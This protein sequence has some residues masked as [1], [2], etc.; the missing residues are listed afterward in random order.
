MVTNK[1]FDQ[2]LIGTMSTKMVVPKQWKNSC[3]LEKL[4]Q[5]YKHGLHFGLNVITIDVRKRYAL[6]QFPEEILDYPAFDA[7]VALILLG[8]KP[9]S[10]CDASTFQ[11]PLFAFALDNDSRLK[12]SICVINTDQLT[13]PNTTSKTDMNSAFRIYDIKNR[14]NAVL[15]T[16]VDT[17]IGNVMYK[18][19]IDGMPYN[20]ND[21]S[22]LSH[23]IVGKLLGYSDDDIMAYVNKW[24]ELEYTQLDTGERKVYVEDIKETKQQ[25]K[26]LKTY[27][28]LVINALM[29]TNIFAQYV[30]RAKEMEK[31]LYTLMPRQP[32]KFQYKYMKSKS[33]YVQTR[34][35]L[36]K[37]MCM[38]RS[39]E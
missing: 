14:E 2:T 17:Q 9:V 30:E 20:Y 8:Q 3:A 37:E 32:C 33:P 35:M 16:L 29:R 23:Y 6:I 36:I 5:L 25:F 1:K 18:Q 7:D 26:K 19:V 22:A 21:L 27:G 34:N 39:K 15:L 13:R 10:V 31:P 28:D 12:T 38:V 24:G 4:K 11:H